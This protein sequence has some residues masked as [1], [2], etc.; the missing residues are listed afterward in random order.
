MRVVKSLQL[1]L[2]LFIILMSTSPAFCQIGY[3]KPDEYGVK[4]FQQEPPWEYNWRLKANN[5]F[6]AITFVV[7]DQDGNETVL[8][9]QEKFRID[10]PREYIFRLDESQMMQGTSNPPL[11]IPVG[12]SRTGEKPYGEST[13]AYLKGDTV[14]SVVY[15]QNLTGDYQ[16]EKSGE[17]IIATYKTSLGAQEYIYTFKVKYGIN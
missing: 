10:T 6:T 14:N 11:S 2:A 17:I 9:E 3:F 16:L 7:A 5:L 1:F 4:Y 8:I 13:W 15:N 12:F